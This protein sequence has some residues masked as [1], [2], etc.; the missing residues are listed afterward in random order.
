M[1]CSSPQSQGTVPADV[2]TQP[3]WSSYAVY[4]QELFDAAVADEK[5]VVLNF[6]AVRCPT[7]T[8]VSNDIMAK[9]ASL[10]KDVMVLEVDYDQYTD[11]KE[12]YGVNVQTTFVFFDE[13]GQ[14]IQTVETIRSFE[15]LQ[16]YL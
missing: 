16:Q 7:C 15:D 1:W 4:S 6:R 13:N 5:R 8:E 9:Q 3:T 2:A 14:Y 12:A 10:P 11:L